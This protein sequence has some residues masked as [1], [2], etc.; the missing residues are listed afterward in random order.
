[1]ILAVG[2]SALV[3]VTICFGAPISRDWYET[4]SFCLL[5]ALMT[6]YPCL[7]VQ[8]SSDWSILVT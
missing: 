6:V 8:V 4:G 1:M 5:L 3:Y 2:W 7:L